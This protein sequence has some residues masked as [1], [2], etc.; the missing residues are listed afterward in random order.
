MKIRVI[1]FVLA[2]SLL[3]M[4]FAHA[5]SREED[6]LGLGFRAGYSFIPDAF[7]GIGFKEY[8]SIKSPYAGLVGDYGF[9]PFDLV[10]GLDNYWLTMEDGVWLQQGRDEDEDKFYVES[11]FG[12]VNLEGVILWKWRVHP[13][14]EPVVGTGLSLGYP[15]GDIDVD[16]YHEG[17]RRNKPQAK[18]LPAVIPSIKLQTGCRFY[19][20]EDLRLFIDM[21]LH[22][23]F[24]IGAGAQYLFDL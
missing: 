13:A 15:Y 24:F 7:L 1:I 17:E 16:R 9:G 5:E 19:P 10:V 20:T 23:G 6:R 8:Q 18:E 3:L 11:D 2:A 14:V 21:G 4:G 22:Y 12:L